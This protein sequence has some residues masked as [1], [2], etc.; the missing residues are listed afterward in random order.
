MSDR[1][2]F[3]PLDAFL[4]HTPGQGEFDPE[5]DRFDPATVARFQRLA[6]PAVR[7]FRTEI[8]GINNLPWDKGCLCI[9]NHTILGL[10]SAILFAALYEQTGRM[11]RGLAEHVVF[12]VPLM[13][14]LFVRFGAVDGN[15]ENAERLL[16]HGEWAICYPGGAKDSFKRAED[17][18][19]LQWHGRLGYLR[20]ALAAGVPLVPIAGIGIDDAFVVLGQEK[21]VGRRLFGKPNYDLPIFVGLGLLPLPVKFRFIIDAQIDLQARYGLGPEDAQAPA[22]ELLPIH[23]DIWSHT[24]AL[25]DRGL[26]QRSSRFF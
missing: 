5:N 16:R 8:E 7:Y 25:I 4:P 20:C 6:L 9:S 3:Y 15:R 12:R 26:A 19:R 11:I 14:E 13:S 2:P 24:Q 18:Y 10:D 1:K 17:R 21:V 23:A 22:E